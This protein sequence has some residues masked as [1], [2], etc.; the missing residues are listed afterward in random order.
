MNENTPF[1]ESTIKCMEESKESEISFALTIS[2]GHIDDVEF[3]TDE[4]NG[5]DHMDEIYKDRIFEIK[6][7]KKRKRSDEDYDDSMQYI[8]IK[9]AN[10]KL[11]WLLNT[12]STH[13]AFL[14]KKRDLNKEYWIIVKKE[15]LQDLMNR[16]LLVDTIQTRIEDLGTIPIPPKSK[17]IRF[18]TPYHRLGGNENKKNGEV[19]QKSDS[20][21][22]ISIEDLYSI[23]EEVLDKFIEK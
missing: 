23:A 9:A 4:R 8:E 16:K 7:R 10:G 21:V 22:M 14:N 3:I 13:F 20:V 1:K 17:D 11:G 12:K 2:N 6:D 15:K 19:V 18:Y 5:N